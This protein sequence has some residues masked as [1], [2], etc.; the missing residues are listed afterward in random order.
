M[1]KWLIGAGIALAAIGL[2][3]GGAAYAASRASEGVAARQAAQAMLPMMP[4]GQVQGVG[5][6]G[7]WLGGQGAM[8]DYLI[9]EV[10]AALGLTVDALEEQL[11]QG[12]TLPEVAE[13]QGVLSEDLPSI[14]E[15]ARAK[16]LAA[17][18][19]DGVLTQEQADWMLDHPVMLRMFGRH[20]HGGF[21]LRESGRMGPD[22]FGQP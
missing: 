11:A 10:G 22:W 9:A 17:A 14:L 15:E 12:Q 8:H 18:V 19:A 6:G 21:G 16:A 5:P 7:G 13:A 3:V 4:G 20:L 1:R 2:V